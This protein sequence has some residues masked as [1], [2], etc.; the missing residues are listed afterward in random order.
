MACLYLSS[1]RLTHIDAAAETDQVQADLTNSEAVLITTNSTGDEAT[2]VLP[3]FLGPS[4][5]VTAAGLLDQ[6]PIQFP[7][8]TSS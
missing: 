6:A 4:V 8:P 7:T 2:T 3:L 5:P 1:S